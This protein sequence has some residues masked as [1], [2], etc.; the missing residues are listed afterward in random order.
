MDI[1]RESS[2]IDEVSLRTILDI[3]LI[4]ILSFEGR[5]S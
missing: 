3:Y 4:S 2:F 5:L 1:T